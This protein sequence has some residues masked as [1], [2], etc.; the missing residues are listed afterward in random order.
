MQAEA[1]FQVAQRHL[2]SVTATTQQ[3]SRQSAQGQLESARGKLQSAQ[4]QVTYGQLKSPIN[5]VVTDRPLFPGETAIS[6][7]TIVTVMDTSSLLAKLHL[8]QTNAQKLHVGDKA[9]VN[10]PGIEQAREAVVSFISPALDAGSTTVEV[11]VK[12]S[13]PRG[14]LKVGTPVHTVLSGNTINNAMQVPV[15]A[16]VPATDATTAVILMQPDGTSHRAVVKVGIRTPEMVQ[17]LS[18]LTQ[19]DSVVIDGGYGLEDGT[20]LKVG[21]P[22]AG[23]R[24]MRPSLDL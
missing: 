12:L 11:W 14:E 16:I 5:G 15:A 10:V 7:A 6:G 13:N 17:I 18:G 23:R 2:E 22:A 9:E 8:A 24:P 3:T 1:A 4:A 21:K 19:S 20:K